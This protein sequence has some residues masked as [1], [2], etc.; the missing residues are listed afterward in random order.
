MRILLLSIFICSV[1]SGNT[2]TVISLYKGSA[3]G[4]EQWTWNEK[5]VKYGK[6]A[7]LLDVSKPTLTAYV[8]ANPNG[9]AIIVAPGGG[10]HI[11]SIN[12]EGT[13]VA[14]WLN[15]KGVTA[16]VLKYRLV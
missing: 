6:T 15:E 7:I 2:Q 16:F 11:L 5:E 13:D 9:T 8:P 1:F 14:K 3:P 10:F 12:N 4:S